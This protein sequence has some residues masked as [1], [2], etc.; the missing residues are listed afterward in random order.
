MRLVAEGTRQTGLQIKVSLL[1][2]SWGCVSAGVSNEN[3]RP[4][5]MKIDKEINHLSPSIPIVKVQM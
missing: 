3:E 5:E 4:F 2:C 1:L